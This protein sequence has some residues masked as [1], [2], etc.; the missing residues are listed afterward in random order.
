MFACC[1]TAVLPSC[2]NNPSLIF[3]CLFRKLLY[4]DNFPWT[5]KT[6]SQFRQL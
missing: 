2:W 4:A 3:T 6:W 1:K 5:Q